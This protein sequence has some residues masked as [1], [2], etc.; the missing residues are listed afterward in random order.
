MTCSKILISLSI[1]TS[2]CLAVFSYIIHNTEKLNSISVFIELGLDTDLTIFFTWMTVLGFLLLIASLLGCYGS[3]TKKPKK[4]PYFEETKSQKGYAIT[5][6]IFAIATCISTGILSGICWKD[7]WNSDES[8]YRENFENYT[9]SAAN[10][11]DPVYIGMKWFQD[12]FSCC[13]FFDLDKGSCYGWDGYDINTCMCDPEMDPENCFTEEAMIQKYGEN[14]TDCKI[15]Y[16]FDGFYSH[17][18]YEQIV[19]ECDYFLGI[20]SIALVGFCVISG[21]AGLCSKK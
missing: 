14:F 3:C 17:G 9:L 2:I 4:Y 20:L 12:K 8:V 11:N 19:F 16:P 15:L 18:C 6:S 7:L 13:G 5:F 1:L 10:E 21:L